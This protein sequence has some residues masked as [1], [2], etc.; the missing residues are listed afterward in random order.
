MCTGCLFVLTGAILDSGQSESAFRMAVD[1]VN[2]N[3]ILGPSHHLTYLFNITQVIATTESI[4]LGKWESRNKG[5][6]VG[7]NKHQTTMAINSDVFDQEC[8]HLYSC[9]RVI[10]KKICLLFSMLASWT[11]HHGFD[12][13]PKFHGNKS[14]VCSL[15]RSAN[16]TDYSNGYK[17]TIRYVTCPNRSVV[18][19]EKAEKILPAM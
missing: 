14:C 6:S 2:E 9:I 4:Q 10:C 17:S 7:M 11:R 19:F 8:R 3:N 16:P 13:S 12:W 18:G 1:F 5:K 15:H